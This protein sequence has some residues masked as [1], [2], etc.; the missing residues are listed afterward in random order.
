MSTISTSDPLSPSMG[1]RP[2]TTPREQARE[3]A[4][5]DV[6]VAAARQARRN[7][8]THLIILA[9]LL[10][11]IALVCT[12]VAGAS[13][14]SAQL[15]LDAQKRQST[16]VAELVARLNQLSEAERSGIQRWGQPAERV[17]SKIQQAAVQAGIKAAIPP[18]NPTR[19]SPIGDAQRIQFKYDIRDESLPALLKW[20]EIATRDVPGLEVYAVRIR[21]EANQWDLNV[22]FSRWERTR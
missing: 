1:S 9:L 14:S 7:T 4:R 17:Q 16:R 21:P 18:V 5:Q 22:T 19:S 3:Q 2:G 12:L 10:L 15:R 11:G 6:A 20:V 13:R 8:P